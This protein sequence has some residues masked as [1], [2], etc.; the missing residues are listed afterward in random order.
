MA[1]SSNALT[2]LI[3]AKDQTS[4]AFR[5]VRSNLVGIGKDAGT[6]DRDIDKFGRGA[7]EAGQK[8]S[9]FGVAASGAIALVA[10]AAATA[11][12]A[13]LGAAVIGGAADFEQGLSVFK[14]T[15]SATAAQMQMVQDRAKALGKDLTLPG[16]S[17]A[18][19]AKA[20][21][22]LS[23]AGLSVNDTLAASKGVLSL[24]KAGQLETARAAEIASNALLA[25][26]LEGKEAT[27][28]A[29]LLAAAANASSSDVAGLGDSLSMA[30][31]V[32]A[33]AKRPV[34][35][36]VTQLAL[37]ANQGVKGSDAGTSLKQ[38]L[39]QLMNPSKEAGRLMKDLGISVYDAE[40]K[41]KSTRDIIG[42]FGKSLSGLTDAQRDA[43]LATV[44]GADATRAAAIL[45]NGGTDAYDKMSKSVNKQGAAQ[46]LAKAYTDGFKGSLEGLK[47][48]LETVGLEI[49]LGLLP[50]LTSVTNLLSQNV[51]PAF[52]AL[53]SGLG[54]AAAQASVALNPALSDLWRIVQSELLPALQRL[55]KEAIEPL[56]PVLGTLLVAALVVAADTIQVL[57]RAFS[58]LVQGLL[59]GNPVI[60]GVVG[61]LAGL[62][63]ALV[64]SA[65]VAAFT[66]GMA[67]MTASAVA[68]RALILSPL[69]LP[70]IGVA[71][72]LAA[73]G[74]VI[75]KAI[76]TKNV[77]EDAKRSIENGYASMLK[78]RQQLLASAEQYV[79][80]GRR[81]RARS[82]LRK[83]GVPGYAMGTNYAPGG[84]ALVGEQ[85][86]ELVNLPRGSQVI[87]APQTRQ[88]MA[89][90]AGAT[91]VNFYGSITLSTAAAVDRFF[92]RLDRSGKLTS[93]GLAA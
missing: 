19:A 18:D 57:V 54:S 16:V 87:P 83:L 89:Q 33:L 76:E 92:E 52:D 9:R 21:T 5:S 17:A 63:A 65:A 67:T 32:A 90:P 56:L 31:A 40:G 62:K 27:R 11:G 82:A 23:K 55:W 39:L 35:D 20:M 43:T 88:L 8:A 24:A 61:A 80:P 85:G 34:E 14:A 75:A 42:I 2:V 79:D 12:I 25:F 72:A 66:A 36:V 22:E 38:M 93:K 29:D 60:W 15:S 7:D 78:D 13:T 69:I 26:R 77:V 1:Q 91:N 48:T 73:L 37:L 10:A 64:I 51:Q 58:G 74:L 4:A 45:I 86:P 84:T 6:A 3:A 81:E 49:G 50:T 53:K 68:F 47:S 30:S 70:A 44:F 46:Q 41:M 28:V 71:A 59:D